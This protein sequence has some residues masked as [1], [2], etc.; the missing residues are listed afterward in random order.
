MDVSYVFENG[1]M[2]ATAKRP[3]NTGDA[4]DLV[5]AASVVCAGFAYRGANQW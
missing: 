4:T 3:F 2:K 1:R 5:P